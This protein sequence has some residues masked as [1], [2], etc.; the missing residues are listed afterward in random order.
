LI[1]TSPIL[2]LIR[3]Y[4]LPL[5]AAA[6][7]LLV[8]IP[9]AMLW[10]KWRALEP[11]VVHPLPTAQVAPVVLVTEAL[12]E[13]P[14]EPTVAAPA[15]TEP[16]DAPDNPPPIL[17]SRDLRDGTASHLLPSPAPT[18]EPP[19]DEINQYLWRV[20][21]RAAIKRDGSGDFTWK[22]VAAAA[23]LGMS[24]GD[25]VIR[26]MDP[27]FRELLYRA[28]RAIDA[29]GISWTI[30]SG[31]RDD[32]R[33]ALAAGYKARTD[34]SLHGG[35]AATGG[36]GHGCAVDIAATEGKSDTLWKWLD[37]NGVQLGLQRGFPGID[38]SH[39]Q[40]RGAWHELA[41][42]LRKERLAKPEAIEDGSEA[43]DLAA[44]ESAPPS[45]AD[46]LCIN[47]HRIRDPLMRDPLMQAKAAD[48]PPPQGPKP[49]AR[50]RGGT[51]QP[52]TANPKRSSGEAKSGKSHRADAGK[53]PPHV[54]PD[55]KAAARASARHALYAPARTGGAA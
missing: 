50:P 43:P 41:D 47:I 18:P 6:F 30:R 40:P 19:L 35:S 37:A 11:A 36:Y 4:R 12:E 3:R 33:Q 45:E 32:Y 26:G 23:R 14:P 54:K 20:Y 21:E 48:A 49:D 52:K 5:A 15:A 10:P 34:N 28:G 17:R 2:A 39:I 31:F 38:P 22:D 42:A 9:A 1:V 55:A 27:D 16:P 29:A 53:P 7:G 25:Y 46:L 8:A 24:R 44:I 13:R 51:G